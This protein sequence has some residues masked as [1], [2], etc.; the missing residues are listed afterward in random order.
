M[1]KIY[2]LQRFL[3]AQE[4]TYETALEEIQSGK[5]KSHW[6]WFIFPQL[7]GLGQSSLAKFYGISCLEEAKEYMQNDVLRKRL[8]EISEALLALSGKDAEKIMGYPDN[9]KLRSCMTLFLIADPDIGVFQQVLDKFFCG[10]P[11]EKTVE[12]LRK[13]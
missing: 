3:S 8:I 4:S 12:I 1:Q 6:M 13:R 10:I 9:L 11:D 2:N 5:K 7:T